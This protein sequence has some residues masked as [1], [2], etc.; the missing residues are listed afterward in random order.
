MA[1]FLSGPWF[2]RQCLVWLSWIM[3]RSW[4]RGSGN[5]QNRSGVS[6]LSVKHSKSS[7]IHSSSSRRWRSG[8]SSI[9]Y[10]GT[11]YKLVQ[12]KFPTSSHMLVC[13]F[14]E[15]FGNLWT[16]SF[17]NLNNCAFSASGKSYTESIYVLLHI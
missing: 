10:T 16:L 17:T 13:L 14:V 11:I 8:T 2:W 15:Y 7:V 3:S 9:L 1:F 12:T 6:R 4:Q 5:V